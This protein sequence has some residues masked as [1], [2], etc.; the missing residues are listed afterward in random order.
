MFS[1]ESQN[2]TGAIPKASCGLAFLV[3]VAVGIGAL[4]FSGVYWHFS[5]ETWWMF[6]LFFGPATVVTDSQCFM[7][8]WVF[9]CLVVGA[10]PVLYGAYGSLLCISRRSTLKRG[11]ALLLAMF[12]LHYTCAAIGIATT[13]PHLEFVSTALR[14]TPLAIAFAVVYLLGVNTWAALYGWP[15]CAPRAQ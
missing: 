7:P 2:S 8:L 4:V 15:R 5:F 11:R 13:E 9:D 10:P 6:F 12:F 14:E 3:A 1:D